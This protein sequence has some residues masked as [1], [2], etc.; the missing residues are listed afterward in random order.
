MSNDLYFEGKKCF[1]EHDTCYK[2]IK[3]LR[4]KSLNLKFVLTK[5]KRLFSARQNLPSKFESLNIL[6]LEI[7]PPTLHVQCRFGIR[8]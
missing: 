7:S 5:T 2:K 6:V 3:E 8:T 4:I 1:F